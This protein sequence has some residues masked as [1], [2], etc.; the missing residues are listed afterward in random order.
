MVPKIISLSPTF[1]HLLRVD[2]KTAYALRPCF[3]TRLDVYSA[4][5]QSVG[6]DGGWVPCALVIAQSGQLYLFDISD[7]R[8]INAALLCLGAMLDTEKVRVEIT[9]QISRDVENGMQ[10]LYIFCK[11]PLLL[12]HLCEAGGGKGSVTKQSRVGASGTAAGSGDVGGNEAGDCMAGI[13]P[14][15]AYVMRFHCRNAPVALQ[16]IR[17]ITM[18]ADPKNGELVLQQMKVSLEEQLKDPSVVDPVVSVPQHQQQERERHGLVTGVMKVVPFKR[19]LPACR[20]C[21]SV[22]RIQDVAKYERKRI[23]AAGERIEIPPPLDPSSPLRPMSMPAFDDGE[24]EPRDGGGA[25]GCPTRSPLLRLRRPSETSAG[26]PTASLAPDLLLT[27]FYEEMQHMPHFVLPHAE[28]V[29]PTYGLPGF[30]AQ[31][32]MFL[33]QPKMIRFVERCVERLLEAF[34]GIPVGPQSLP[35]ARE[36]VHHELRLYFGAAYRELCDTTRTRIQSISPDQIAFEKERVAMQK[37]HEASLQVLLAEYEANRHRMMEAETQVFFGANHEIKSV[38]TGHPL[39]PVCAEETTEWVADVTQA[40]DELKKLQSDIERLKCAIAEDG[41]LVTTAV[42][43]LDGGRKDAN[44]Q[45]VSVQEEAA[46]LLSQI[47]EKQDM[48]ARLQMQVSKED[49]EGMSGVTEDD[50]TIEKIRT[51]YNVS[52][53]QQQEEIDQL[54]LELQQSAASFGINARWMEDQNRQQ[55]VVSEILDRSYRI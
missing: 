28:D 37:A 55:S 18:F 40:S 33:V 35:L 9:I 29:L 53:F 11:Q 46:C 49:T 52:V 17:I 22:L 19:V 54:K 36:A 41:E 48:L 3:A 50:G 30:E 4:S 38:T 39:P 34:P 25:T 16:M 15:F 23:S 20:S 47:Q 45:F 13:Y 27:R 44:R 31:Y 32:A 21:D 6:V 1:L 42:P 5:A 51:E 10:H 14:P 7:G 24:E 26:A 12:T 8:I 43:M 2:K